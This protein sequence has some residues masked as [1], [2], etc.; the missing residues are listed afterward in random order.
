M[1]GGAACWIKAG[2]MESYTVTTTVREYSKI[3][4]Y[5]NWKINAM[6]LP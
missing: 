6:F 1:L 3:D 4:T 5:R 2:A